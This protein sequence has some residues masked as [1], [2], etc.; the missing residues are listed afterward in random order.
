MEEEKLNSELAAYQH[1][2][3][4]LFE[5]VMIFIVSQEKSMTKWSELYTQ[6][7]SIKNRKFKSLSDMLKT[8]SNDDMHLEQFKKIQKY[9]LLI[10]EIFS[11]ELK[12]AL[13]EANWS[14]WN[15]SQLKRARSIFQYVKN[16]FKIMPRDQLDPELAQFFDI[17]VNVCILGR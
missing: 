12:S 13:N 10:D 9:E 5:D 15:E 16:K 3:H 14:N 6:L 17:G 11:Q 7:F 1:E 8:V 4:E 2:I